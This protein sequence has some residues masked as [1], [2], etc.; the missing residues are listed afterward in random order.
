M[1]I[2]SYHGP[3][4]SMGYLNSIGSFGLLGS[5][6]NK[7]ERRPN[8]RGL[9]DVLG[10]ELKTPLPSQKPKVVGQRSKFVLSEEIFDADI[11]DADITLWKEHSGVPGSSDYRKNMVL[12]TSLLTDKFGVASHKIIVKSQYGD[13]ASAQQIKHTI[14]SVIRRV[15]EGHQ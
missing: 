5:K 1:D 11:A 14:M 8:G 13:S 7:K 3:V 4:G 15:H 12:A 6:V 2:P 9:S 10:R